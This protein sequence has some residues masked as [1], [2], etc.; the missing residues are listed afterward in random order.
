MGIA[1]AGMMAVQLGTAA[2]YA[3]PESGA[4]SAGSPGEVSEEIVEIGSDVWETPVIPDAPVSVP[5]ISETEISL[6]D[7]AGSG[8]WKFLFDI[9][10][11]TAE[12]GV[13]YPTEENQD[14]DFTGWADKNWQ[15]SSCRANL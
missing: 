2:P 3:D 15:V 13:P 4:E 12:D 8:T 10:D 6:N 14:F 1:L 5:G 11:Y 9:P 7:T